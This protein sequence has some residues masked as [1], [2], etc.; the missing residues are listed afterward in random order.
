[1]F[2]IFVVYLHY[3]RNK[4]TLIITINQNQNQKVMTNQALTIEQ[5]RET[6]QFK[7]RGILKVNMATIKAIY[8]MAGFNWFGID[9]VDTSSLLVLEKFGVC[10]IV[11]F[12]QENAK[13]TPTGRI[14]K[15]EWKNPK[16]YNM[17][18][19]ESPEWFNEKYNK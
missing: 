16:N 1:M 3:Q 17:E 12:K 4:Q 11:A 5:I 6:K 7:E 10:L 9:N 15:S 8:T 2:K 18:V 13:R 19:Q 14:K